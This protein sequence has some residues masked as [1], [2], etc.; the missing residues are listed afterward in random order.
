MKTIIALLLGATGAAAFSTGVKTATIG[1]G[2][3]AT[4]KYPAFPV[5]QDDALAQRRLEQT[6]QY[7]LIKSG[8]ECNSTVKGCDRGAQ[9]SIKV[10]VF[11]FGLMR[12]FQPWNFAASVRKMPAYMYFDTGP[13]LYNTVIRMP[14]R[15]NGDSNVTTGD[16]HKYFA[17]VRL[18][19][20][21]NTSQL[22]P[23]NLNIRI[24]QWANAKHNTIKQS[25]LRLYGLYSRASRDL[26]GLEF[27]YALRLRED[28]FFYRDIDV[29]EILKAA[30]RGCDLMYNDCN[31]FGGVSNRWQLISSAVARRY[32]GL[33]VKHVYRIAAFNTEVFEK[34]FA[35]TLGVSVCGVSPRLVSQTI[36]R[37]INGTHVC[38]REKELACVSCGGERFIGCAQGGVYAQGA[39]RSRC[40]KADT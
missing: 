15:S 40:A 28:S 16:I 32:F 4:A 10:V 23:D 2:S 26:P 30:P 20:L 27:D 6:D 36:S 8:A 31:K 33:E 11:V 37:P 24:Q 9:Q 38:F 22:T 25:I 13:L 21:Y 19:R 5:E 3:F 14:K 39:L 34:K 12:R 35:E 7:K 17:N 29:G 18:L 1:L